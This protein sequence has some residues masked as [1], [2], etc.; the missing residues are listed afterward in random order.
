L[1]V[2]HDRLDVFDYYLKLGADPRADDDD[3]LMLAIRLEREDFVDK[4][5]DLGCDPRSQNDRALVVATYTSNKSLIKKIAN[6]GVMQDSSQ[7]SVRTDALSAAIAIGDYRTLQLLVKLGCDPR[8]NNSKAFFNAIEN[9]DLTIIKYLY[10]LG[11]LQQGVT[12]KQCKK[13]LEHACKGY[14][15]RKIVDFV[16]SI[17]CD[18]TF[19][20]YPMSLNHGDKNYAYFN[21]MPKKDQYRYVSSQHMVC[22]NGIRIILEKS[23]IQPKLIEWKNFTKHNLFRKLWS[24]TSMAIQLMF[25]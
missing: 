21:R 19:E 16:M 11:C 3:I 20:T 9:G 17:G 15:R 23:G 24:P 12:A 18:F 4:L 7:S 22:I 13:L 1:A 14:N 10:S 6:F 25:I 2:E 8:E 5:L